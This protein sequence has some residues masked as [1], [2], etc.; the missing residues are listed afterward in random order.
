[1]VK[2]AEAHAQDDKQKKERV[3]AVNQAEGI[4]HDVESKVEEYQ[5]QLPAEEV[6]KIKELIVKTRDALARKDELTGEEIKSTTNTLQQASL[7]LFELAYR[8]VSSS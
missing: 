8:K 2:N 1:M 4:I 6:T 3:E 7:K 5:S